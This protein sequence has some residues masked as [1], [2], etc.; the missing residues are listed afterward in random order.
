ML[1]EFDGP[2]RF[3]RGNL[4]CHST[5]SDGELSPERVCA[6]YREAGYDFVCVTDHF[7]A[8]CGWP[9]TDTT[10]FRADGFTTILGAE[11]HSG[12]IESGEIWHILAVGL[13]PDFAPG[14][15]GEPGP[16]L[17][18]RALDAGAFVALPHPEWYG[19]TINDALAMPEGVHAVEAFNA[20]ARTEGREGG[21]HLL[22]QMLNAGRRPGVIAVDDAHFYR[23][24]ALGG[25]VMVRAEEA[26]PEAILAAL[27][28]GAYYASTGPEIRRAEIAGGHLLVE[29]SPVEHAC[30]LGGGAR[31]TSVSGRD[32]TRLRLPLKRFAGGWARLA[33]RDAD[34]RRAWGQPFAVPG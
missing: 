22:D 8:K 4:H 5:A 20:I 10:D 18:A 30:L 24:D 25:W 15:E 34:G 13:P 7:R 27:K 16:A 19:L 3:L 12:R 11:L 32:M 1:S 26:T 14:G 21:A 31:S 33:L 9:I 28:A 29:T 6:F 2:G 17:A 23:E